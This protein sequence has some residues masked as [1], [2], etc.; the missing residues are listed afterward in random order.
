V[1]TPQEIKALVTESAAAV[2]RMPHV[3]VDVAGVSGDVAAATAAFRLSAEAALELPALTGIERLC[4]GLTD[5]S[6]WVALFGRLVGEAIASVADPDGS[7]GRSA[8]DE[9]HLGPVL[10]DVFRKL[11]QGEFAA[12]RLVALI[13]LLRRLPL[14]GSVADLPPSDR[15]AALVQALVADEAVRPYIQVNVWEGVSWFHRESF[16]QLLWW[17]L[18]L[19]TLEAVA[20]RAL[21]RADVAARRAEAD[22]LTAILARAGQ[23]SDYQLGK[24]EDAAAESSIAD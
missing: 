18:A 14:P 2:E 22:R 1:A 11:G 16:E 9:L 15:A 6:A 23:A 4:A 13:R 24:L 17:M 7:R 5:S 19:D 10:A 12:V 3:L 8:V 21:A 20:D